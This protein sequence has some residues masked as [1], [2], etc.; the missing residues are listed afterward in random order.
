MTDQAPRIA[1][2]D[3]PEGPWAQLRGRW[4]A[5]ELGM[6]AQW[7]TVSE[8]L[9]NQPPSPDL[10]WD[11]RELDWLDHVGAQL[12]WNHW[13]H[14]WPERLE[15]TDSQRSM[16]SRVAE[17]TTAPPPAK[18]WPTGYPDTRNWANP[19]LPAISRPGRQ[20]E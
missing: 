16:L 10:G 6:K 12:L 11:L 2:T 1:H 20:A 14:A 17:F 4:G 7:R 9:R 13:Q 15:C 18:D 8:Q 3:S 19:Q 5:A